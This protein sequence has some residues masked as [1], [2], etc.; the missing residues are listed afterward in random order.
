MMALTKSIIKKMRS[1]FLEIFTHG[2]KKILKMKGKSIILFT[3]LFQYQILSLKGFYL[4]IFFTNH[5]L[6]PAIT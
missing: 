5:D 1:P 3:L 2:M 4:P 6:F